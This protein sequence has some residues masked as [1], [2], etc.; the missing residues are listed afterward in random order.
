[1]THPVPDRGEV[2]SWWIT[3]PSGCWN[4]WNVYQRVNKFISSI[5]SCLA[6]NIQIKHVHSSGQKIKWN[7]RKLIKEK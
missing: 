2:K 1:M 6:T 5:Q 4:Q 7:K 3:T